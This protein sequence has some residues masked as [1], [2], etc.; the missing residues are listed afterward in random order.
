MTR[1]LQKQRQT[2]NK[3]TGVHHILDNLIAQHGR[4]RSLRRRIPLFVREVFAPYKL[5]VGL[6]SGSV[7]QYPPRGY[8]PGVIAY[9]FQYTH[10][11]D[12]SYDVVARKQPL[13]LLGFGSFQYTVFVS[14]AESDHLF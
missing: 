6:K 14:E 4:K 7:I 13:E 8:G 3:Q 1:W 12:L 9:K 11:L 2:P 5:P 10:T